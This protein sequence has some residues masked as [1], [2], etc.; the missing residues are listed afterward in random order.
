[1]KNQQKKQGMETGTDGKEQNISP[2]HSGRA[3][4]LVIFR[5]N[6]P[7]DFL[8]CR[9]IA[10]AREREAPPVSPAYR[11]S[12]LRKDHIQQEL[13]PELRLRPDDLPKIIVAHSGKLAKEAGA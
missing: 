4:L 7:G 8:G 13:P 5:P 3:D 9:A 11:R 12:V 1:M 6:V 2:E 10:S